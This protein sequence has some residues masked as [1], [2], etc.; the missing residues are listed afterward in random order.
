[1]GGRGGC[2]PERSQQRGSG[3]STTMT[4][5]AIGVMVVAVAQYVTQ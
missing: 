4:N 1:M 2:R 3:S 5:I